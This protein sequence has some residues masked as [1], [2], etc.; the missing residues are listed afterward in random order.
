MIIHNPEILYPNF[1]G[2]ATP[3]TPPGRRSFAVVLNDAQIEYAEKMGYQVKTLLAPGNKE[4]VR[5]LVVHIPDSMGF[6]DETIAYKLDL[7]DVKPARIALAGL[8]WSLAGREGV[9]L[10]L[11]DIRF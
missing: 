6:T 5:A 10:F 2:K 1:R 11:V 8:P 3:Y 7:G 4:T 9:K